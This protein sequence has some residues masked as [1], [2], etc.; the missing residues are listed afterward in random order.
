MVDSSLTSEILRDLMQD[1]KRCY[2]DFI[3]KTIIGHETGFSIFLLENNTPARYI[4]TVLS[5]ILKKSEGE[6]SKIV[7]QPVSFINKTNRY[8]K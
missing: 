6:I 5:Q 4:I 2:E 1:Q 3:L 7:K 8:I